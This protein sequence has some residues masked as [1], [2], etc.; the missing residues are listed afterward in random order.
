MPRRIYNTS[1]AGRTPIRYIQRQA[2]G[3]SPPIKSQTPDAMKLPMPAPDCSNPPPLPRAWSGQISETIEA[4]V[5][6]SDPIPTP[7]RKRNI[8]KDCQFQAM[9][10]NPVVN[11]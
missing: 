2:L 1:S 7:T 10:L 8:A 4:P 3:P 11:E 9:A 6:H 5:A